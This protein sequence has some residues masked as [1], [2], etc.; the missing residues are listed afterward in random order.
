[1]EKMKKLLSV[2]LVAGFVLTGAFAE[3]YEATPCCCEKPALPN[4]T[5]DFELNGMV[6]P[7]AYGVTMNYGGLD[8]VA[9]NDL[10]TLGCFDL[11]QNGATSTFNLGLTEGNWCKPLNACVGVTC[12]DFINS[13]CTPNSVATTII[14]IG[15]TVFNESPAMAQ[16][17]TFGLALPCGYNA[18]QKIGAFKIKWVGNKFIAAGKYKAT[19]TIN[20]TVGA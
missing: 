20:V 15:A 6:N 10:Y 14:P 7:V 19:A 8:L 11:S 12:T 5:Y 13:C 2:L 3:V 16:L 9:S 1:M 17:A 18:A 4:L